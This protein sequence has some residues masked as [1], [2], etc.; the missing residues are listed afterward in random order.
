[1]G[2]RN[3]GVVGKNCVLLL[4]RSLWLRSLSAD[5]LCPSIT[6]VS[7]QDGMLAEEYLVVVEIRW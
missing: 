7:I 1:M 2:A 5:N 6:V 3:A 4:T